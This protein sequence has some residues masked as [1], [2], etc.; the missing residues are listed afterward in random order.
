MLPLCDRVVF[1][2]RS[3]YLPSRNRGI[4]IP[5]EPTTTGDHLRR[6]R[7]QFNIFQPH[8]ARMLKVRTVSLSRWECDRVFPT[9][10]YQARILQYL[11]FDPFE[12][13]P[14]R[15]ATPQKQRNRSR[16]LFAKAARP[17]ARLQNCSFCNAP[18]RA[19]EPQAPRQAGGR[20]AAQG[21]Q[22]SRE[23]ASAQFGPQVWWPH[24]PRPGGLLQQSRHHV[25]AQ[26]YFG[27]QGVFLRF[28]HEV[29][30]VLGVRGFLAERKSSRFKKCFDHGRSACLNLTPQSPQKR[31]NPLI[32]EIRALQT[33]TGITA[34][35]C[36]APWPFSTAPWPRLRVWLYLLPI[37]FS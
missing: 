14:K 3:K 24:A 35:L 13:T 37:V 7:L 6:R 2:L 32:R 21:P 5:R 1:I 15:R 28:A 10:S 36:P 33:I 11:G 12:T 17:P 31:H 18:R 23:P 34:S 26:T 25:A 8:V 9:D 16:C 4:P 22:R 30:G 19:D 20:S 29:E 27:P